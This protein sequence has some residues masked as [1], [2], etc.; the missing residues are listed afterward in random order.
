MGDTRDQRGKTAALLRL[1]RGQRERTHSP[2]VER[3][4]ERDHV[5]ALGVIACQLQCCLNRFRA[6]V[7]VVDLMR[8]LHGSDLDRRSARV[9]MLS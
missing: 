4:V 5:L 3:A 1:G 8:P 2:S 7:A 6:R 9:T